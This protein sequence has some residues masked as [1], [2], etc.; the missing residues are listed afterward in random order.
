[1]VDEECKD[2]VPQSP[3]ADC[4][5][6]EEA[7]LLNR[8]DNGLRVAIL[9]LGT[10]HGA[11][12]GMRFHTAVNKF[13]YQSKLNMP[14]TVWSTALHQRRPYLGLSDAISAFQHVIDKDLFSGDIYNVVT[15]NWTVKEIIDCIERQNRSICELELV[16]SPIMNQLSYE[17]SSKKFESTGFKFT[18]SLDSDVKDTLALLNRV[19]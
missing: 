16:D 11:S 1:M 13:I 3:Y 17:V 8:F 5:L 9:R 18:G 7:H 6:E 14:I 19:K 12:T 2:L 4:K 10:I 15:K